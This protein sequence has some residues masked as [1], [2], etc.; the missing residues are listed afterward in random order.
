MKKCWRFF[1]NSEKSAG[2]RIRQ[3]PEIEGKGDFPSAVPGNPR[4]ILDN[5][6]FHMIYSNLDM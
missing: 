3:R 1:G 4:I 2:N 6:A 5:F